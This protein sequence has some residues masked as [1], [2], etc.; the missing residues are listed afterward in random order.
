MGGIGGR[1]LRVL[2]ACVVGAALAACGSRPPAAPTSPSGKQE[3]YERG[4]LRVFVCCPGGEEDLKI[5][6]RINRAFEARH[7]GVTVKQETLPAGTNYF[8]KLQTMIAAGNP[9]DVFDMWE[10]YVQPYA[11]AGQLL[12]LDPYLQSDPTISKAD[13]DPRI[14]EVNSWNG[15]VYS[16]PIEYVPYPAALFYNKDLF[17]RAG[18]KPPDSSWDW[19]DVLEAARRLTVTQGGKVTQW[20]IAFD[21]S[22]YP[23]W[24]Y[25]IWANGADVFNKDQTACA[26]TDPKAT[27]AI[28]F[29]ADMLTRYKV[30]PTATT[31]KMLGGPANAFKTGKVAM[32]LGAGW[33]PSGFDQNPR[34]RYG[35]A[36]VPKG[37]TGQRATYLMNLTWAISPQSKMQR[38]AWEYVKYF[39]TEGEKLRLEVISSVPSYKPLYSQWLTP[40]KEKKGYGI[41]IEEAKYAH[42]PGAGAKWDK[43]STIIQSELDLVFSGREQASQ[44]AAKVCPRVNA[45]LQRR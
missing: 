34:L 8:E 22:F 45:E 10:G 26:L 30:A 9:P 25:W 13:F 4:V 24:L 11:Q 15:K 6:D 2:L 3:S 7:P 18:V 27:Q 29:W 12:D 33:E 20:G 39:A 5:R 23:T 38:T 37:L 16:L 1:L 19:R 21:Y 44:A 14:L 43:I 31:L 17:A 42:I 36:L 32:Y 28:Q 35:F 40:E 41:Y